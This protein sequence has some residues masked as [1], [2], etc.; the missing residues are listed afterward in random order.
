MIKRISAMMLALAMLWPAG[1]AAKRRTNE[2]G[3]P[4]IEF[5]QTRY[6]FGSVKEADGVLEHSFTFVNTG[7]A[8]LTIATVSASCGCTTPEFNPR[9]VAPGDS[10]VITLRFDPEGFRGE[11]E[12]RAIVRTNVKGSAGRATLVLTGAIIPKK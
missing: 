8:P 9:P 10:S 3:A 11:F 2:T 6:D 12:K 5:R 1:A 7:T 4:A